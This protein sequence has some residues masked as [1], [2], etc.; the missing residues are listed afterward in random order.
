MLGATAVQRTAAAGRPE[1]VQRG[2]GLEVDRP[3]DGSKITL[4]PDAGKR[5]ATPKLTTRITYKVTE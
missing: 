5:V 1:D 2:A 3:F 4:G